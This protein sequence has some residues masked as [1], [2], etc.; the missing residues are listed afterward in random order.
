MKTFLI[1]FSI[2]LLTTFIA[3][4]LI[5]TVNDQSP[6]IVYIMVNCVII[7]VIINQFYIRYVFDYKIGK[8]GILFCLFDRFIIFRIKY[9][10]I[11]EIKIV[12]DYNILEMAISVKWVNQLWGKKNVFIRRRKLPL[13]KYVIISPDNADIFVD[14]VRFHM[15]ELTKSK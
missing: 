11:A 14:A 8:D 6:P 3:Y 10:D 15:E 13:Y 1:S 5:R 2:W 4:F 9:S 12:S 7:Y